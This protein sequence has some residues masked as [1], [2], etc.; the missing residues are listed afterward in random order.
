MNHTSRKV[1][2]LSRTGTTGFPSEHQFLKSS[3]HWPGC[4]S[5]NDVPDVECYSSSLTTFTFCSVESISCILSNTLTH[6][7]YRWRNQYRRRNI[8][9]PISHT[10]SSWLNQDQLHITWRLFFPLHRLLFFCTFMTWKMSCPLI[11]PSSLLLS[12]WVI[13]WDDLFRSVLLYYCLV[14]SRSQSTSRCLI[15]SCQE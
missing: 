2:S 1:S 11:S 8:S 12:F 13:N 7:V 3:V 4:G 14:T 10:T 5:G 9:H 6:T 15:L